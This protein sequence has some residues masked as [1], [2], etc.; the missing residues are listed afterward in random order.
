[1]LSLADRFYKGLPRR[2]KEVMGNQIAGRPMDLT[3]LRAWALAIDANQWNSGLVKKRDDSH[4]KSQPTLSSSNN[5]NSSNSSNNTSS[6]KDTSAQSSR[7][8]N[9][10]TK[11]SSSAPRSTA[12]DLTGKLAATGKLTD[13]ERACRL[14][15]NLCL[16][17]GKP[18]HSAK[19]NLT[20]LH[21]QG[22]GHNQGFLFQMDMISF[23]ELD[24]QPYSWT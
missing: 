8:T 23:I 24:I 15:E 3:A 7:T 12:P 17:C 21:G 2:I 18:G 5:K 16:Y 19:E 9:T 14:K 13:E 22:Q 10:T 20:L 11:S 1:M 6:K 4:S